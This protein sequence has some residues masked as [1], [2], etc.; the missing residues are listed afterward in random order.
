MCRNCSVFWGG[1]EGWRG[2]GEL[3]RGS[4]GGGPE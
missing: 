2:F 4:H 3:R 1:I